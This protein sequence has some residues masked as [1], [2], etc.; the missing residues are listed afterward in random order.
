MSEQRHIDAHNMFAECDTVT[1]VYHGMT[2]DQRPLWAAAVAVLGFCWWLGSSAPPTIDALGQAQPPWAAYAVALAIAA[3]AVGGAIACAGYIR[4]R[5]RYALVGLGQDAIVIQTWNGQQVA[6]GYWEIEQM[7]WTVLGRDA[8]PRPLHRLTI[9]AD[10]GGRVEQH[11]IG[12]S[13]DPAPPEMEHL[14]QAVSRRARLRHDD[15][16]EEPRDRLDEMGP[17]LAQQSRR[18]RRG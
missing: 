18:W 12:L 15:G 2:L 11:V 17:D 3:G 6:V 1:P 8:N 4:L 10:V 13:Q 16:W 9:R 7:E 5:N 14:A